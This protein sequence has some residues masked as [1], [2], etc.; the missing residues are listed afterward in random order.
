[1]P[2]GIIN[3]PSMYTWGLTIFKSSRRMRQASELTVRYGD[4]ILDWNA[5]LLGVVRDWTTLSND[6]YPNRIVMSPPPV[7]ARNLA[8]VHAAMFDAI[9]AVEQ[10]YQ[11]YLVD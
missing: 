5:T 8:M 10:V 7:V 6:P 1:M 3:S 4:V 11:H 2:K 9:N